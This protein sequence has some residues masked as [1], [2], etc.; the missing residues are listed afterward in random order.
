MQDRDIACL[1]TPASVKL[2]K[3]RVT[4]ARFVTA[5]IRYPEQCLMYHG[6]LINA[7]RMSYLTQ[8]NIHEC[9]S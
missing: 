6:H 5:F 9:C 8:L 7:Y 2:L 3:Q 1:S 4:F